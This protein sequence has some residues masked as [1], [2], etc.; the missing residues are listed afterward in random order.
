MRC[1]KAQC[2]CDKRTINRDDCLAAMLQV[3][4]TKINQVDQ[5]AEVPYNKYTLL[6][7]F[8]FQCLT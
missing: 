3:A 8:D 1:H 7:T 4:M 5:E 6:V 2:S